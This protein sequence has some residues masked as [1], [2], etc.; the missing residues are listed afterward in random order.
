VSTFVRALDTSIYEVYSAVLLAV[1]KCE[2]IFLARNWSRLW[3]LRS[4]DR[5]L[6]GGEMDRPR[7]PTR[8]SLLA[9]TSSSFSS[10]PEPSLTLW[11]GWIASQWRCT[12]SPPCCPFFFFS[13]DA[14]LY[15]P[16]IP[17]G[18]TRVRA[19]VTPRRHR[20][21]NETRKRCC[22]RPLSHKR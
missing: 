16:F 12:C 4:D 9:A 8:P 14:L 2:R 21:C 11:L 1:L 18:V 22:D 20:F 13:P 17:T 5:H 15:A 7:R 6:G 19:Y 3:K 10:L